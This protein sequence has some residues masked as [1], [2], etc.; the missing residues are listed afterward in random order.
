MTDKAYLILDD[1]RD[2]TCHG[3]VSVIMW[4]QQLN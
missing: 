4:F 1:T 2:I 3:T